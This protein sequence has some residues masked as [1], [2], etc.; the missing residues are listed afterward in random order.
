MGIRGWRWLFIIE[1]IPALVFGVV[2]WFYLT[3]RPREAKWLT[4]DERDWIAQ[5]L[6]RERQSKKAAHTYSIWQALRHRDVLILTGAY[7]VDNLASFALSFWMPTMI[8]RISGLA[9]FRVALL[10]AVPY[11]VAVV[12]MQ[13]NGWHSD[14][15]AERRWH[16]AIPLLIAAAALLPLSLAE[17]GTIPSVALFA[18]ASAGVLAFVPSFWAMP[19]AFLSDS[20]AAVSTGAINCVAVGLGGFAGPALLGYLVTRTNSFRSGF[21]C[22]VAALVV[23]GLLTL[24]LR[25]RCPERALTNA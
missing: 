6:E 19:S 23:A 10:V 4:P 15:T 7:F 16:S 11:V 1:G 8:K 13:L 17:F 25:V 12:A 18:V 5:Q 22:L 24:T 21:A 14:R 20:A 2:T 3:D 9:N